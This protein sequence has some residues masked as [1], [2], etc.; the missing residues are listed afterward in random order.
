[1]A[2]DVRLPDR[3]FRVTYEAAVGYPYPTDR[4]RKKKNFDDAISA[5]RQ[6]ASISRMPSHLELVAV[7]V[8]E[9]VW[10]EV[11][12]DQLPEVNAA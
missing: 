3:L 8:G 5:A 6:V 11:S 2:D 7:H 9:V 10:T 1:M 12:V 4:Q